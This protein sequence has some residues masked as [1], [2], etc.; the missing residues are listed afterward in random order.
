MTPTT[1]SSCPNRHVARHSRHSILF[2]SRMRL[3]KVGRY[4]EQLLVVG[5]VKN[6]VLVCS[7]TQDIV[8]GAFSLVL[9]YSRIPE[10]YHG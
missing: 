8:V 6:C 5:F 1:T 2:Y 7:R 10:V 3:L 9:E 4:S